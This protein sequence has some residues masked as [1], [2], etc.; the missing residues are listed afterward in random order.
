MINIL[1]IVNER[2]MY[3][4]AHKCK[5]VRAKYRNYH[6]NNKRTHLQLKNK[7]INTNAYDDKTRGKTAK[8]I[9]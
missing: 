8:I 3:H 2:F 9:N 7:T 5:F 6:N 4:V 1:R